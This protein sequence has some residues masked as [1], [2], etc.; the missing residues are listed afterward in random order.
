MDVLDTCAQNLLS[1]FQPVARLSNFTSVSQVCKVVSSHL[2]CDEMSI[3]MGVGSGIFALFIL[4]WVFFKAWSRVSEQRFWKVCGRRRVLLRIRKS[5]CKVGFSVSFLLRHDTAFRC[6]ARLSS[7]PS[8]ITFCA[9]S[10]FLLVLILL[11]AS[12]R[13]STAKTSVEWE[14]SVRFSSSSST[15]NCYPIH[16]QLSWHVDFF[17]CFD[18][19]DMMKLSH[20]RPCWCRRL[21]WRR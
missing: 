17:P 6:W 2:V 13:G 15:T 10:V 3:I 12:P 11:L 14:I 18:R 8:Q 5:L 20:I 16:T 7:P 21:P 1:T 4:L 9:A 19:R